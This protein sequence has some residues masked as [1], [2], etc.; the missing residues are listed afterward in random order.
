MGKKNIPVGLDKFHYA[1]MTD[2]DLET[3]DTPVPIAGLIQANV[4]PIVNS[5]NLSADDAIFDVADSMQGANVTIGL[6]DIPTVDQSAL[7]GSSIDTNGVL[8]EK[9]TDHAPYVAIGYRRKMSNGKYRYM[10]LYKGR[11]RPYDENADTQGE[12]PTFQTPSITATFMPRDK[13]SEWRARANEGDETVLPATLTAWFDAVYEETPDI[14]PLTVT[15]DPLHEATEVDVEKIIKWTFDKAINTL[16]INSANF[17]LLD[18]DNSP[19]AGTLDYNS[20]QK[21][22]TFTPTSSLSAGTYTA[23][24]TLGVKDVSGKSLATASITTFTVGA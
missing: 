21:E 1:V 16:T 19:V 15:V 14:T 7:L 10:W 18:S 9:N 20:T 6:A 22:I 13:D 5:A 4:S 12:T 17:F 3:Y 2:E 24:A 11:F 23:F 8:I